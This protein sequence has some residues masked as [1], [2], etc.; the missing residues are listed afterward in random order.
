M[1]YC[2]WKPGWSLIIWFQAFISL[3]FQSLT[4]PKPKTKVGGG[5][6]W[7][8]N[9]PLVVTSET[10]QL[11]SVKNKLEEVWQVWTQNNTPDISTV[12]YNRLHYRYWHQ[13]ILLKKNTNV[14]NILT[15]T[16]LFFWFYLEFA[17]C[18]EQ[19][20]SLCVWFFLLFV[21]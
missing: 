4:W 3:W 16:F 14:N 18:G 9:T 2:L 11:R 20:C 5:T 8:P 13:I 10:F 15:H 6:M 1:W 19:Q 21:L 7:A 17:V 12:N